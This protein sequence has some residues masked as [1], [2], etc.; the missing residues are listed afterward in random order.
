MARDSTTKFIELNVH[1]K[2]IFVATADY[3]KKGQKDSGGV[4]WPGRH[5]SEQWKCD[6]GPD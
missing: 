1:A 2:T 4:S 3:K 5:G 6:C